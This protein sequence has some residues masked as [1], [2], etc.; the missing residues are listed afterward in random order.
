MIEL[1]NIQTIYFIGIGGIGMSALARYFNAKGTKVSGYDRAQTALTKQLMEEG[2]DIHFEENIGL[3]PLNP[4]VVVYTPAIPV[5]NKEWQFCTQQGYLMVKRS[6]L[7]QW[8]TYNSFNICISGT[9]GKTTTSTMIAHILRNSGYGC[10]AFLGGISTN[11]QTNFWSSDN[12][13]VV[14]EADEYDRSFL[15]LAPNI[16]II[17]AIDP[18]HLDI[19]GTSQAVEDAFVAFSHKIKLDGSLIYHYGIR[20]ADKLNKNINRFTYNLS[21][22]NASIYATEI[23]IKNGGYIFTV[24][25]NE[26]QLSSIHLNMGGMHNIENALAAI[27][28]AKQL[29]ISDELIQESI[30]TF[31]GVKR[32][33]EFII[34][35]EKHIFIDDYAHHP[36]ELDALIQGVRGLYPN[37]KITLIFQPHLYSRTKDFADAFAQSL[38]NADQIILLPIYPARELPIPGIDSEWLAAKM[39]DK[40]VLVIS[41]EALLQWVQIEQPELMITAGAGDIDQLIQPLKQL[42]Q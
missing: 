29:G 28:V 27:L 9:H 39:K 6:D 37:K 15:K 33:F 13:V 19:Y 17:T 42:L 31:K 12:N 5:S 32:R 38:Q 23:K 40:K 11:Y 22:G 30:K 20:N 7:L 25:S 8:I 10:N 34:K 2:I 14:V 21:N 24:Q 18:D 36:A 35:S 1:K 3:I 26:W 16:A 41:K 4:D